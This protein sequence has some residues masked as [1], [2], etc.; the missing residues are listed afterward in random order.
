MEN[1]N[2]VLEENLFNKQQW[3]QKAESKFSI[4]IKY[5]GKSSIKAEAAPFQTNV[6]WSA[7][8][9]LQQNY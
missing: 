8:D 4:C 5:R 2:T 3:E 7:R 9:A 6:T 1:N